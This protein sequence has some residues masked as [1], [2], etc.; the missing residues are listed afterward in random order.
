MW[1]AATR[2]GGY[3]PLVIIPITLVVATGGAVLVPIW[4]GLP[5]GPEQWAT[6]FARVLPIV[7]G[8]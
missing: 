5:W 6:L 2:N 8:F 3:E 1:T 7:G 4:W